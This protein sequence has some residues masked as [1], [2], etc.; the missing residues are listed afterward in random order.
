MNK[1]KDKARGD[2]NNKDGDHDERTSEKMGA[3][4]ERRYKY[5]SK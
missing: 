4:Y 1:N 3:D 2:N 5:K